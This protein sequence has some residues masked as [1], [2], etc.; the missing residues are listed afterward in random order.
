MR[1]TG[2]WSFSHTWGEGTPWRW[3]LLTLLTRM[4]ETKSNCSVLQSLRT[5]FLVG[6]AHNFTTG[7]M[8]NF[9][10]GK[11]EFEWAIA[12]Y[13]VCMNTDPWTQIVKMVLPTEERWF[14]AFLVCFDVV[15]QQKQ[16]WTGEFHLSDSLKEIKLPVSSRFSFILKY[17]L[18]SSKSRH[19]FIIPL[20][21]YLKH[22]VQII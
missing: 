11:E 8:C 12:D 18:K 14:S 17:Y 7:G 20:C 1:R 3:V 16:V 6:K 21:E 13:P 5:W 22:L 9:Q 2:K 19:I 4:P 10:S 15:A